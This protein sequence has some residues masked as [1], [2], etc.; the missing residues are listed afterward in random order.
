MELEG[1]ILA[2]GK[3]S[4]DG[5][6]ILTCSLNG[7]AQ[8][9]DTINGACVGKPIRM[10]DARIQA[11]Q[12]SADGQ[13]I[14]TWNSL[15]A[16]LWDTATGAPVGKSMSQG[17]R[18]EGAQFSADGRRV[19]TWSSNPLIS[20]DVRLWDTH[21]TAMGHP[22]KHKGGVARVQFSAN[23]HRFLI[24][25]LDGTAQLWD[26]SRG[27]AASQPMKLEPVQ[28][29]WRRAESVVQFS[30]DGK[31]ILTLS[32]DG[33][34]RLW[35]V[36]NG[37]NI[38]IFRHAGAVNSAV[39]NR[40]ATRVL[41]ASADGTTR[42]WD[43]S[44]DDR[45]SLRDRLLEFEVRSAT[46]LGQ[47]GQVRVLSTPEWDERRQKLLEVEIKSRLALTPFGNVRTLT[48]DDLAAKKRLLAEIQRKS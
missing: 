30:G 28:V 22:M 34:A 21:G 35:S 14:L 5:G 40:D 44:A 33:A 20:T 8:V 37:Q 41:T 3:V 18:I 29:M 36:N 32:K 15:A 43:I 17:D 42:L 12:F 39:F 9:R 27:A 2:V 45:I 38:A 23:G 11:A 6:R 47:D 16:Q 19:L 25:C 7:T 13:R 48:S 4:A 10:K 26:T 1:H 31:R 46:T 24:F